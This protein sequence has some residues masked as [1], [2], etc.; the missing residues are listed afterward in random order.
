MLL[1]IT[2]KAKIKS[3]VFA[4]ISN[5]LDNAIRDDE[6]STFLNKYGI[7]LEE[8]ER[9]PINTRLAKVLVF[10]QLA[11]SKKDYQIV[12][13]KLGINP[14]NIE[15]LDYQETKRFPAER[16]RN[17][18]QYSDI[19]YGPAPHKCAEMGD[20]SS[21]L[22]EIKKNPME[23]PRLIEAKS[24]TAGTNL[25]ISITVFKECIEK[26]FYYESLLG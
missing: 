9:L 10:G 13:K 15:F 21:L 18:M 17:S 3:R 2:D 4:K 22:A 19:I 7:I 26:T 11:G 14:E 25:K 23:Y 16:L 1:S 6:L 20:T 24:N 8:K 12:A 5:E